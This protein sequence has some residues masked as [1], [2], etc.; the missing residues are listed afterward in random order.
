MTMRF[1]TTFQREGNWFVAHCAELGVTSQ[2]DT[3]EAAERNLREAI[4]LYLE[5]VPAEERQRFADHPLIKTIDL[6]SA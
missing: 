1:T 3:L 6:E 2:G 4:E 5:D